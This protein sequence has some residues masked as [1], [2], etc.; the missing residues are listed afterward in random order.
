M[1]LWDLRQLMEQAIPLPVYVAVVVA[2]LLV[3]FALRRRRP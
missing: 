2:L 1:S 3:T